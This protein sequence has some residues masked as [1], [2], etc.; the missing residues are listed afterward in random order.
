MAINVERKLQKERN[1]QEES[2]KR[3]FDMLDRLGSKCVRCGFLDWR[4]LQID[5]KNGGA[6]AERKQGVYGSSSSMD[7]KFYNLV[8]TEGEKKFQ[9]LCSNCNWIKRYEK[10]EFSNSRQDFHLQLRRMGFT[11]DN[12]TDMLKKLEFCVARCNTTSAC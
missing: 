2:L 4:A 6:Y 3:R 11:T 7:N 8:M 9:L 5:H 12:I 1:R 10:N